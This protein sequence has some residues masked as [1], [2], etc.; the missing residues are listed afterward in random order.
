M[1]RHAFE[2]VFI[3][4]YRRLALSEKSA[5]CHCLAAKP[6]EGTKFPAASQQFPFVAHC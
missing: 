1:C 5:S 4:H 3:F 6:R 2:I